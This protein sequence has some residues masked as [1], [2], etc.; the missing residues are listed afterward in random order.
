MVI[1]LLNK[2][3]FIDIKKFKYS[4]SNNFEISD[5]KLDILKGKKIGIVGPSASGKSTIIEIL[6]GI[7]RSEGDIVV[8][9]KSIFSNIR[10]WQR[11]N[12][13]C[14]TKNIYIG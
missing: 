5:V 11:S 9:G 7:K 4:N 12:W 8:D 1:F 10:G 13:I 3:I 14:S 6:T 2:N